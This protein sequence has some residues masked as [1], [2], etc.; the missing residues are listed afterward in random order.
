MLETWPATKAFYRVLDLVGCVLRHIFLL[1]SDSFLHCGLNVSVP[2]MGVLLHPLCQSRNLIAQF[3][4]SRGVLLDCG[5]GLPILLGEAIDLF[6]QLGTLFA[7]IISFFPQAGVGL[8]LFLQILLRIGNV[9]FGLLHESF[10]KHRN[11]VC[12]TFKTKKCIN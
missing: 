4:D 5:L 10:T 7:G 8:L 12:S 9:I 11:E 6:A 3:F 1:L 2:P